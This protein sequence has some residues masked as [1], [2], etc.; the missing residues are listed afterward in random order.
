MVYQ[1]MQIMGVAWRGNVEPVIHQP[2]TNIDWQLPPHLQD[3]VVSGVSQTVGK[4][5]LGEII[6]TFQPYTLLSK[7]QLFSL[8][9]HAKQAY[10]YLFW[11]P[12][13]L[14]RRSLK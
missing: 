3:Y 6:K 11:L 8:Y 13:M 7:A 5:K 9:S 1:T 4:D 2:D 14:L 12:Q 10:S